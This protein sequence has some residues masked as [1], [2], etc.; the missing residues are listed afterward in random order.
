[1]H[2][3]SAL[4]LKTRL[5]FEPGVMV[6]SVPWQL[7]SS[8]RK[9]LRRLDQ[10]GWPARGPRFEPTGEPDEPAAPEPEAATKS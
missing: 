1:L 5:L 8:Q 10:A 3:Q 6:V 4:R 7:A 2:N 9:N